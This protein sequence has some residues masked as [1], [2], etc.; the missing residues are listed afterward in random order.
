MSTSKTP[1]ELTA[2]D[3]AEIAAEWL[4]TSARRS[5]SWL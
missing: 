2:D 5:R 3:A 1:P 4:E